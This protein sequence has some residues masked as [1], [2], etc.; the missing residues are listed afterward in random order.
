MSSDRLSELHSVLKDPLRQK[1]LLKLGQYD[2]LDF[3]GLK[4]NLKL[5]D[6][7]E[8][9]YQLNTLQEMTVEG[10]HLLT[11]QENS[12]YQLTE[13]GHDVLDKMISFPEL[14]SDNFR[15]KLLGEPNL[16]KQFK[17]KP[18]WFTSYWIVLFVSTIIVMG[19]VI[20]V[21]GNQSVNKA[22]IYTVIALL[23]LGLAFYV[24]VKPSK[25][26]NKLIYVGLLGFAL[27]C[28]FWFIGLFI[29]FFSISREVVE[30]NTFFIVL[31]TLSFTLGP[32]VGYLIGKA[33]N[34]KGPAQYS[35]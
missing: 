28:L 11:K 30:G 9:S 29:A 3:D 33:R 31:T 22:I 24:R 35:P 34:F 18:K 20:P 17:A 26:L 5:A 14:K 19:I 10:E 6:S 23:L 27:G 4:K 7:Q 2:N 8:L 15:E 25:R 12:V 21:F 1:I 16:S 13:K 32:I